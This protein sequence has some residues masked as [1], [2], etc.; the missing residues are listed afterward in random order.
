MR[1]GKVG[2][3]SKRNVVSGLFLV[4]IIVA[5][6]CTGVFASDSIT[7]EKIAPVYV[8]RGEQNCLVTLKAHVTNNGESDNIN[9]EV[10]GVDAEGYQLQTVKLN[11]TINSGATK[12]LLAQIKMRTE[13][14]DQ[15]VAWEL[16]E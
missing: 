5:G 11:G 10:I 7:V 6:A 4:F 3:M 8:E 13:A 2:I 16:R 1:K 15:V 12:V 9:I 14:F